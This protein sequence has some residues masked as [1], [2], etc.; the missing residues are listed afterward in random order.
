MTEEATPGVLTV[1]EGGV[2]RV[3]ALLLVLGDLD[4]EQADRHPA[5]GRELEPDILDA[6][7]QVGRLFP[8][9]LPVAGV[10]EGLEVHAAHDLVV[11]AQGVRQDLV[12]DDPA[13]RRAAALR[14]EG[15]GLGI[16]GLDLDIHDLVEVGLGLL[17]QLVGE[18]RLVL[19][20]ERAEEM[21]NE[22]G[23]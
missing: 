8:A 13:D 21:R 11:V 17:T 15:L 1:I 6:V 16:P 2:G 20:R 12:E 23:G 22:L 18:D 9:E 5:A 7:D 19:R 3:E 14:S 10:D 4:V